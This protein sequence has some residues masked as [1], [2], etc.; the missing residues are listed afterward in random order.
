[1]ADKPS[2]KCEFKLVDAG[3]I[4]AFVNVTYGFMV[5][6]DF[7]IVKGNDGLWVA[8][9][10]RSYRDEDGETRWTD[11]IWIPDIRDK[12]AFQAEVLAQFQENEN[13]TR[14]EEAA[15]AA[16]TATVG[17]GGQIVLPPQPDEGPDAY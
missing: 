10:S 4:V 3:K 16:R 2:I 14:E 6:K 11:T 5:L 8:P 15:H 9:P 7:K 1:M 13:R 17:A 12:K